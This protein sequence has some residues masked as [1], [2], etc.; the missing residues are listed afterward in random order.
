[1]STSRPQGCLTHCKDIIF[2]MD[3]DLFTGLQRKGIR[4]EGKGI[5]ERKVTS[6]V[7]RNRQGSCFLAQFNSGKSSCGNLPSDLNMSE[8]LGG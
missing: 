8:K 5:K 4:L 6:S 2:L 7:H 3:S 1:M